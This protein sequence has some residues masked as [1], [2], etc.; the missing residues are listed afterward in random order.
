MESSSVQNGG[1]GN[2]I[3]S[4]VKSY[5]YDILQKCHHNRV[6]IYLYILNYGVLIL[7]LGI[8]G[9]ILYYSYKT[10]MTPDEESHKKMR[11]QAYILEK[12]KVY[13]DHQRH[14]VQTNGF[15]K[16]PV[17]DSALGSGNFM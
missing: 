13:K 3:E 10:K 5:M 9:I 15:T 1:S 7:F 17:T 16:L 6:T 14:I 2:L 4:G 12:I 11:D 8:T